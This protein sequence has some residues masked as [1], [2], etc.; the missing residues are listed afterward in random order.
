MTTQIAVTGVTGAIG[1]QVAR[2][3]AGAGLAPRLIARTP[4]RAPRL[5]G[6]T[7]HE[8]SYGDRAA[9]LAALGGVETLLMVSAAEDEHRLEQHRAFVDAAAE[10][11]V[12]HVVYTSFAGAAPDATFT[13]ARD[14]HATEERIRDSGMRWTFL[15]DAFYLDF[16][17]ALVG[18][19]GVIRGPA[20]DGR[21][22]AVTRADV[23]EVAAAVLRDPEAHR[24]VTYDLTGPEALSLAEVAATLTAHDGR[25]V[26]Y[27]DE[28]LA[29]A[30]AS[31]ERWGAP[32]WQ[33]DAWVSTYTAMAA[34]EMAHVS[35]DVERVLG[36]PPVGLAAFL[37]SRGE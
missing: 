4:A 35:G 22:A 29:E 8:A 27:R 7:V 5:A 15:R 23:A 31:R 30:Y 11:G 18:D 24:D 19:D 13:L 16:I 9:S 1:G 26:T 36:R 25:P 10:A 17:S 28:T 33:V 37:A 32:R 20:G 21:V 2:R 3:L 34:G 14:H 6:A 12:R